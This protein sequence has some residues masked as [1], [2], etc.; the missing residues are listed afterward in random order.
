MSTEFFGLKACNR[1]L[2]TLHAE[3]KGLLWAVSCMRDMRIRSIFFEMECSDLVDMTNNPMDWP[4]FATEI[5]V[6]QRLQENFED[7]SLSHI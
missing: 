3:M 6:F 7:V 5:E 1:N 2:S 4:T